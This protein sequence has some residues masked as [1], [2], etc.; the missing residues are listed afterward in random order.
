MGWA[1]GGGSE[2]ETTARIQRS[3]SAGEQGEKS[4]FHSRRAP[5]PLAHVVITC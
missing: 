4:P 1:D 2:L 3:G 5:Q